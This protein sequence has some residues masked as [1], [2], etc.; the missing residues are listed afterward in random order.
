M[1]HICKLPKSIGYGA[2]MGE[3]VGQSL[4]QHCILLSR[5]DSISFKKVTWSQRISQQMV[6]QRKRRMRRCKN[7]R[8]KMRHNQLKSWQDNISHSTILRLLKAMGKILKVSR[9][10]PHAL[11]ERNNILNNNAQH[12][13]CLPHYQGGELIIYCIYFKDS[14]S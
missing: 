12:L 4:L 1:L 2:K 11:S 5:T 13:L 7:C 6:T 10:V 8:M 9:W 14:S 3:S